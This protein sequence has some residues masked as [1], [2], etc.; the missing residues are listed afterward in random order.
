MPG[1]LLSRP[2]DAPGHAEQSHDS[3]IVELRRWIHR[4]CVVGLFVALVNSWI[5]YAKSPA[6][7]APWRA[8]IVL[9]AF[10]V[11][12]LWCVADAVRGSRQYT[13]LR[14]ITVLAI[15]TYLVLPVLLP[16]TPGGIDYPAFNPVAWVALGVS[17]FAFGSAVG[18]GAALFGGVAMA[19][20]R[21]ISV[22]I[23][24]GMSEAVLF[25]ASGIFLVELH[26]LLVRTSDRVAQSQRARWRL[27]EE[28]SRETARRAERQRWNSLL[29]DKVLGTLTL[30]VRSKSWSQDVAGRALAVEAIDA[31]GRRP[32]ESDDFGETLRMLGARLGLDVTLDLRWGDL[33]L[34]PRTREALVTATTEALTNVARH[35][36][37]SRVVV[38]GDAIEA[39]VEVQIA[40]RGH[41]FD[42]RHVGPAR[43]GLRTSVSD[44]ML[45]VD[46]RAHVASSPG[47]GTTVTLYAPT[48]VAAADGPPADEWTT[49]DFRS[50]LITVLMAMSASAVIGLLHLDTK[51]MPMIDVAAMVLLITIVAV[52]WGLESG[53][54]H[55]RVWV[56]T[57]LIVVGVEQW[58]LIDPAP[59]DWR[60]WFIGYCSPLIGVLAFRI[61]VRAVVPLVAG[62]PMI[63]TIVSATQGA[64]PWAPLSGSLPQLLTIGG[65]TLALGYGLNS[66]SRRIHN[67]ERESSLLRSVSELERLRE[68]TA[69]EQSA[70]LGSSVNLMLHRLADEGDLTPSEIDA[71]RRL[72]LR[73][74]DQLVAAPVLSPDL[75]L[76]IEDARDRG[77][78]VEVTAADYGPAQ[79]PE[80]TTFVNA[81]HAT[82]RGCG[83]EA[84]VQGHWSPQQASLLGTVTLVSR[85]SG[86]IDTHSRALLDWMRQG[87]ATRD[88]IRVE[89]DED[90]AL[91][92]IRRT[93]ECGPASPALTTN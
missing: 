27:E 9:A 68:H 4:A 89:I 25:A 48:S 45:A 1:G 21:T 83:P 62:V 46:G 2:G 30:A 24:Q 82:L 54:Q 40:D 56:A 29:H 49:R 26:R 72:E 19:Y 53:A 79:E 61:G 6:A 43:V 73:C 58:N 28:A 75:T 87:N 88:G 7:Y 16:P 34:S 55:W 92:T 57:A 13:G 81:L 38:T 78:L 41:G 23:A 42:P 90:S 51:K 39:G 18:V 77:A 70:A 17:S 76:A 36:G 32:P 10:T 8:E 47:S 80:R 37:T 20:E 60:Y 35:A 44:S 3:W 66:A 33:D 52:V 86:A 85:H 69:K 64:V 65:S 50:L 31:L 15:V 71:C 91:I 11:A 63:T 74:R 67:V 59:A 22:G 5:D 84:V 12:T 93:Q 14:A